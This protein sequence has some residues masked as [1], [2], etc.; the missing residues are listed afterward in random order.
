VGIAKRRL[1]E[2]EELMNMA[3]KILIETGQLAECEQHPGTYIDQGGD[4]SAA[5]KLANYRITGGEID[6]PENM[7]RREFTDIIK[8]TYEFNNADRCWACEKIESED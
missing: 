7:D 6:I 1:E 3:L 8:S 2:Q 5:Y 4:L